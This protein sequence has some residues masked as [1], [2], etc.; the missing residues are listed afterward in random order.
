MPI[1]GSVTLRKCQIYALKGIQN[2]KNNRDGEQN[3]RL[4]S[5]ARAS[6]I[7]PLVSLLSPLPSFAE[8]H[9]G[10]FAIAGKLLHCTFYNLSEL[11]EVC[12]IMAR[13]WLTAE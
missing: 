8:Q 11:C 13:T 10:V 4:A 5:S 2:G 1:S 7:A 12:E 9:N 6:G 3:D